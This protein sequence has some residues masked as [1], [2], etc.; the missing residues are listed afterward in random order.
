MVPCRAASAQGVTELAL[1]ASVSGGNTPGAVRPLRV[2]F[3]VDGSNS[4]REE[5]K[6]SPTASTGIRRWDL[7]A[8][9]LRSDVRALTA[10]GVPAEITT[11]RFSD[12]PCDVAKGVGVVWRGTLA[13]EADA[14]QV[15]ADIIS[16]LGSPSGGTKLFLSVQNAV[17]A[18]DQDLRSGRYSGGQII[19]YSDGADSTWSPFGG[20]RQALQEQTVAAVRELRQRYPMSNVVLRTFGNDARA[21]AKELPDLIDLTGAALR[22]GTIRGLGVTSA[23]PWPGLPAPPVANAVPG[24]EVLSW[25]GLAAPA[26]TPEPIV[27][28]LN[29]ELRRALEQPAV[30]E[31]LSG[32][33]LDVRPM[34]PGGMRDF[35]SGQIATWQ[36]VVREAGIPQVD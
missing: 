6:E 11:V 16:G 22:G 34:T 10:A 36:R 29:E 3:V 28:R 30:R 19:V 4:M 35:V 20:D 2:I 1:E 24:F 12:A 7:V 13:S 5:E 14:E 31:T 18:L 23:A 26:G 9:S 21:V 33:G 32:L 17:A 8:R 25:V 15:S 27:T